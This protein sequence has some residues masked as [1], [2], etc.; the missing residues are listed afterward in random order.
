MV[1]MMVFPFAARFLS[2]CTIL[3]AMNAS[4]PEVGSSQN[5]RAGSVKIYK[6]KSAY[7]LKGTYGF[8]WRPTPMLSLS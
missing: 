7:V 6:E 2:D 4:S 8:Q 1:Q 5:I 3:C